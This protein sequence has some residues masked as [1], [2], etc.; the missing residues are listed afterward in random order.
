MFQGVRQAEWGRGQHEPVTAQSVFQ[1]RGHAHADSYLWLT[2]PNWPAQDQLRISGRYLSPVGS[3]LACCKYPLSGR[4][5]P[6]DSA[7]ARLRC[8]N[9][10]RDVGS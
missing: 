10:A 6:D 4:R 7:D 3:Q 5:D 1:L 9:L 2:L 8:N